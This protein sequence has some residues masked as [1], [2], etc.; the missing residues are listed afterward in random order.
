MPGTQ[1]TTT[2]H[3]RRSAVPT[4]SVV[5]GDA[6]GRCHEPVRDVPTDAP[7][8]RMAFDPA[9]RAG[10]QKEAPTWEHSGSTR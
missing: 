10:A 6:S 8:R 4:A 2:E 3:D 5:S 1:L 7:V 9:Q